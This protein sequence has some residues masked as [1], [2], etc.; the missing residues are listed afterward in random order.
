[1]EIKIKQQP[2]KP[3]CCNL[4]RKISSKIKINRKNSY[5]EITATITCQISFPWSHPNACNQQIGGI[6]GLVQFL[7]ISSKSWTL[8][9]KINRTII[10]S[11]FNFFHMNN[12]FLIRIKLRFRSR[13]QIRRVIFI[14]IKQITKDTNP[15]E[16]YTF[17]LPVHL[18]NFP[19]I[20]NLT[21][22]LL[23][24]RVKIGNWIKKSSKE[25]RISG[26][27]SRNH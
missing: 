13:S 25:R 2:I 14:K 20:L 17:H 1:M 9:R 24:E 19:R 16:W 10:K 3:K 22:I 12:R 4:Q 23:Q 5:Q 21:A 8:A 27:R 15:R 18:C 11:R 6:V 26:W 7:I